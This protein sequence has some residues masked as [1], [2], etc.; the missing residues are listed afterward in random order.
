MPTTAA[1]AIAAAVIAPGVIKMGVPALTAHMFIFYFAVI[2]AITPPVAL[3]SFAAAGMANADP[4]KSSWVAL[5]MGL[6]TFIVP[7]MF[8]FSPVLLMQGSWPEIIQAGITASIGVW[9]LGAGTEGW[10]RGTL[11]IPLRVVMI[12]AALLCIHPGTVTD[13]IGIALG[14]A[15]YAYQTLRRGGRRAASH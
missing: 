2:S 15:V 9:F 13:V 7:F 10:A 6:A 14:A 8:F 11:A 5:K 3:A 1:Y 12:V 4:W